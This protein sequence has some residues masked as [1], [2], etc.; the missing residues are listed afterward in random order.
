MNIFFHKFK[1]KPLTSLNRFSGQDS[2]EGV[3]LKTEGLEGVGFCEYFPHPELGDEDVDHFLSSFY[4]QKSSAQKKAMYFLSPS[5]SKTYVP[6]HFFNHQLVIPESP[7]ESTVLKYKIKHKD[8]LGFLSLMNHKNKIRLD[9]NGLF[10][11]NSWSTFIQKIPLSSRP[12]IEYIEDP[13]ATSNWSDIILPRASDFIL[14]NPYEIKIYKPYR[15]FYPKNEKKVIF[16][17]NLG[18]GLANYQAYLELVQFGN[19]NEHH[20]LLTRRIYEETPEL[21]EG[22]YE[23]GFSPNQDALHKYFD[24]L[25]ALN[26]TTL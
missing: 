11:R 23:I 21:F 3:F 12:Y 16:S 17:G 19:L 15:E 1:L 6:R 22:N 9:A 25:S 4:D 10:D 26:W 7:I 20:G 14:G 13:F 5:W 18:H 8:D 24:F 2:R